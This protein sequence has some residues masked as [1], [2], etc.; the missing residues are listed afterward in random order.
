M[1]PSRLFLSVLITA[2]VVAPLV[3]AVA[4]D[5]PGTQSTDALLSSFE[6]DRLHRMD[7][8]G[9]A[10][11]GDAESWGGSEGSGSSV[12]AWVNPPLGS[13]DSFGSAMLL[14]FIMSTGDGWDALM[15]SLMDSSPPGEAPIRNDFRRRRSL[16]SRGCSSAP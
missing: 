9:P 15:F 11:R 10:D 12:V 8:Q 7:P 3:G 6:S 16:R 14:L 5:A 1:K 4:N 2:P 13:F